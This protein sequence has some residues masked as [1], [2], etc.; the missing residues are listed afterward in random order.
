[1]HVA[2]RQINNKHGVKGSIDTIWNNYVKNGVLFDKGIQPDD[3]KSFIVNSW[4]RCRNV[5]PVSYERFVLPDKSLETR[6]AI[7]QKLIS[8]AVPIMKD[9]CSIGGKNCL[10]LCDSE[11]Y[12]LETISRCDY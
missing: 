4:K 3:V 7:N 1:M 6:L 2:T 8:I 11:G 10:L 12:V 9:I 5:D